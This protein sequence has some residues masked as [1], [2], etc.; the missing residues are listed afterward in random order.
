M[1]KRTKKELIKLDYELV[2]FKDKLTGSNTAPSFAY[3]NE[4]C[5]NAKKKDIVKFIKYDWYELTNL[6]KGK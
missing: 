6:N 3:H 5:K 1:K 4:I 2:L